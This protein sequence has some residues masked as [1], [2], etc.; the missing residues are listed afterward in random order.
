MAADAAEHTS[1]PVDGFARRPRAI[2]AADVVGYT[3]LMEAAEDETHARYREIR[4]NMIDP[5]IVAHRGELIKNTGDGFI[6]VF[7]A[8]TDAIDCAS[9]FQREVREHEFRCAPERRIDFRIGAHWDPVIFDLEDVYGHGVNVAVRLQQAAPAGGIVVSSALLGAAGDTGKLKIDD[10]GEVR[11]KNLS[12]PIHAFSIILPGMERPAHPFVA[13][14]AR[15][16][17]PPSVAVLPF[18]DIGADPRNSYFGD[19]LIEDIIVS[20]SNTRELLVVSRGSSV[21]L[22]HRSAKPQEVGEKLGVRYIVRGEVRRTKKHTE[23]SV[24]LLDVA[25]SSVLWT[26]QYDF[27][28]NDVFHVQDEIAIKVVGQIASHVHRAE[29]ER[30]LRKPPESLDAYDYLLRGLDLLHRLDA[31]SFSQ[32][33]TFMRQATEEDPSYA[34]ASAYSAL[35]RCFKI[36]EIGST[37]VGSDANEVLRLS[38][39]AIESDPSNALAFA[40]QGHA[41]GQFFRHHDAALDLVDRAIDLSPSDSWAWTFSSGVYGYVGE[42][43]SAISRAETAIRLSPLDHFSFLRLCLLA[44]NHYLNGTFEDAIRWSRRALELNP[45]FGNSAR[46]LAATYVALNRMDEAKAIAE[47]HGRSLPNFTVSEYS[48]RCPFKQPAASVYVERLLKAGIP[49]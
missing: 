48:R 14:A 35:W 2:L 21:A 23:L 1:H 46:I 11:L 6:A 22:R 10:L 19:G 12:R 28:G 30:A 13:K 39:E 4:V 36:S 33:G 5:L 17:K 24:E 44:Q 27:G 34:T 40:V 41:K 25:T 18:T 43:R 47:F 38:N 49:W 15:S 16:A 20:L 9:S 42:T 26:E 29:V 37:D 8:A 45:K 7:E 3:R 32:A 31:N